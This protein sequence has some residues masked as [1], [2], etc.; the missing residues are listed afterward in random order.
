[1]GGCVWLQTLLLVLLLVL[2]AVGLVAVY[3]VVTDNAEAR[4]SCVGK[5]LEIDKR[6]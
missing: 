6:W 3:A 1:M 2:L 5:V 4:R